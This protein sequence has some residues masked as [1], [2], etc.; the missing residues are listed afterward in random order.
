MIPGS[1]I[2][3]FGTGALVFALARVLGTIPGLTVVSNVLG[4]AAALSEDRVDRVDVVVPGGLVNPGQRVVGPLAVNAIRRMQ[5]DQLFLAPEGVAPCA[6]VTAADLWDAEVY[7][8][9]AA[10]SRTVTVFAAP[11]ACLS[12]ALVSCLPLSRVDVLAVPPA[13]HEEMS[14]RFGALVPQVVAGHED[15]DGA[16]DHHRRCP[17]ASGLDHGTADEAMSAVGGGLACRES[18]MHSLLRP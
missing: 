18:S 17:S 16:S 1:T 4:I 2:G 11:P 10:V 13:L 8:A 6:G 15:S 12:R 14:T 7:A 3:L 5:M 9:A